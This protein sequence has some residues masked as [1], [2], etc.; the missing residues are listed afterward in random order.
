MLMFTSTGERVCLLLSAML[1]VDG[2]VELLHGRQRSIQER[3]SFTP[4]LISSDLIL[5]EL[6][7]D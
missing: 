6:R 7:C 2:L 5:S 1:A 4:H 3:S